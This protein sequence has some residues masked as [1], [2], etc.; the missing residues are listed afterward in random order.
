MKY[1]PCLKNVPTFE[2]LQSWH[3]RSDYDNFWQKCYWENRESYESYDAL[4]S[5]LTCLV[6][7]HYLAK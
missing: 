7:L 3:T 2:L 1:T 5:H 6:L 4:F